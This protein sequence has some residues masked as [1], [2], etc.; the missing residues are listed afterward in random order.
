MDAQSAGLSK[1]GH[2]R[3]H[4]WVA[5]LPKIALGVLVLAI[6]ISSIF[7]ATATSSVGQDSSILTLCIAFAIMIAAMSLR[8]FLKDGEE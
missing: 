7:W 5:V 1:A 4:R 8:E 6:I 3:A 2:E